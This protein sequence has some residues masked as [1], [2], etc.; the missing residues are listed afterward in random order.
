VEYYT[1]VKRKKAMFKLQHTLTS[2]V[3]KKK[4]GHTGKP[5]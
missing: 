2:K 4:S 5:G 3:F 1:A